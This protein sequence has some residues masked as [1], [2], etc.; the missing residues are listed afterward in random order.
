MSDQRSSASRRSRAARSGF[1]VDRRRRSWRRNSAAFSIRRATAGQCAVRSESGKRRGGALRSNL[2]RTSALDRSSAGMS[3]DCL[4]QQ[5]LQLSQDSSPNSAHRSLTEASA[6][7]RGHGP[8]TARPLMV[9][10]S[11]LVFGSEQRG[12]GSRR[13]LPL[14]LARSRECASP[15]HSTAQ[16][17]AR[18]ACPGD[19][20]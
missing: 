1:A 18:T 6:P 3:A 19:Q 10:G 17:I 7:H 4:T 8:P 15:F 2:S 16:R 11:R 14:S 5:G 9:F 12:V 13:W 20:I